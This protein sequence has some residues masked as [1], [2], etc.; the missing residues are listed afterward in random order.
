MSTYHC[1]RILWGPF[2]KSQALWPLKWI[3]ADIFQ[4][5]QKDTGSSSE[6]PMISFA[7]F[8][9]DFVLLPNK[10]WHF[11]EIWITLKLTKPLKIYGWK[12]ILW[13]WESKVSGA[14]LVLGSVILITTRPWGYFVLLRPF[15]SHDMSAKQ[16]LNTWGVGGMALSSITLERT[17]NHGLI[18]SD[19]SNDGLCSMHL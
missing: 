5:I 12:T 19:V 16:S 17:L 18:T 8:L 4:S 9:C 11:K 3:H 13:F 14:L 10:T 7:W 1:F 15:D 6:N 2:Y